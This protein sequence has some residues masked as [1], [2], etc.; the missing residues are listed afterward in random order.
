[1]LAGTLGALVLSLGARLVEDK[2]ENASTKTTLF[3]FWL[4]IN[5]VSF[6]SCSL[7]LVANPSAVIVKCH[8]CAYEVDVAIELILT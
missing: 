2:R 3:F 1:M 7:C 8:S 4:S 6:K 5:H